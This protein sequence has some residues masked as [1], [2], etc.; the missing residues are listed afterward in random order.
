MVII[1]IDVDRRLV[2]SR[3]LG[4]CCLCCVIGYAS[5]Y[6]SILIIR[7]IMLLP[8][9]MSILIRL[10]IVIMLLFI[11]IIMFLV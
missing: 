11:L 8:I 7:I 4:M 9:I 5:Y 10:C 3:I 2:I 1:I 6:C